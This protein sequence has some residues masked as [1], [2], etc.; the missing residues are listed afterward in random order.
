MCA[1]RAALVTAL[2]F[3]IG[4]A[5]VLAQDVTLTSRDGAVDISGTLIAYDGE[6]FRVETEFGIL[7]LDGTGVVCR[8]P[9]CPELGRYV[10]RV[11]IAGAAELGETLFPKLIES[12]AAQQGYRLLR[13]VTDDHN[14]TYL[15][16]NFRGNSDIAE[17]S[18]ALS[19]SED[20]FNQLIADQADMVISV[21]EVAEPFVERARAAGLG[22]LSRPG[23]GR[24]IA[25]DGLVP[26]V[27]PNNP[28]SALS[29]QQLRDILSGRVRNW[30]ELSG[31]DAPIVLHLPRRETGPAAM[32]GPL[33]SDLH[34]VTT[35][36][37]TS[38]DLT[39]A[40]TRDPFA[41]GVTRVSETGSARVLPLADQCGFEFPATPAA[42]KT[43]DYPLTRPQ[44]L[45]LPARRFPKTTREFLRFLATDVAQ[46]AVRQAGYTDQIPDEISMA[47]QG[48]RISAAVL[49]AGSEVL[50]TDLQDMIRELKEARR[51]TMSFRFETGSATLDAQ[52]RANLSHLAHMLEVGNYDGQELMF[53]GFSD[54]DGAVEA[55]R[56]I[57]L[58]RAQTVV[59]AIKETAPMLDEQAIRLTVHAFG[60]AMPIACDDTE[61]GRRANRRVELW[62]RS[63]RPDR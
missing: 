37:G 42:I 4:S 16:R 31:I 53:V 2:L 1:F 36:H 13:R 30:Q 55:N 44:F 27:S 62:L 63:P 58:R 29:L 19:T 61:W 59:N 26:V 51:L 32:A 48:Q 39:D 52:S 57:A 12:F 20:G 8:G 34:D 60:E 45:Y 28:V 23:G 46:M 47:D 25:L 3:F 10:A 7:T 40:V 43:E 54:G 22:D 24:L 18:F 35:E 41:L 17:F 50:L 56:Q 11:R 15:L 9:G 14:F 49:S 33:F 6:F 5:R 21:R 38:A